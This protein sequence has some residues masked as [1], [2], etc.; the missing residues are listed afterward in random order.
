MF[1]FTYTALILLAFLIIMSKEHPS[2]SEAVFAH[3]EI[4]TVFPC[5]DM[6]VETFLRHIVDVMSRFFSPHKISI[7]Q[8]HD[9]DDLPTISSQAHGINL[10][11][12]AFYSDVYLANMYPQ[13]KVLTFSS[14]KTSLGS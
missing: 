1:S 7:L 6:V 5:L 3:D 12:M 8:R 13:P 2:P 11:M 10:R 4:L 14:P 9:G